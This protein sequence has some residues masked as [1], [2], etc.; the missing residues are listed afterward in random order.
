[1]DFYKDD[2]EKYKAGKLSP[3]ERHALEKKALSDP[4]LADAL[5]GVE[6]I[7][8]QEFSLDVQELNRKILGRKKNKWLWP[9]RIAASVIGVAIISTIIIYNQ[10]DQAVNLAGNQEKK[11]EISAPAKEDSTSQ[12]QLKDDDSVQTETESEKKDERKNADENLVAAV[13]ESKPKTKPKQPAETSRANSLAGA[14]GASQAT[15]PTLTVDTSSGI[16]SRTDTTNSADL[17]NTATETRVAQA[18][19]TIATQG[20]VSG[21]VTTSDTASGLA[22]AKVQMPTPSPA[23]DDKTTEEIALTSLPKTES[24]SRPER[25]GK[26]LARRNE[27]KPSATTGVIVKG[28]VRDQQGQPIPGVNIVAKGSTNG[29]VTDPEGKYSIE[30]PSTDQTLV[31]SFIGYEAQE[32]PLD[33]LKDGKLDISLQE[34]ATQLSEVVV[35]GYGVKRDGDEP[36]VRLAEPD[37]GRK[38]YDQYLDEKKIYPQQAIENKVEGKVTIEFTVG[39]TGALSDFQVVRKLGYGCDEE[40]IRLVKEGPQWKPSYINNEA[41]ESLVRIKTRFKLPGK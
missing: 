39:L 15:K 10:S 17:A 24:K 27:S 37:G 32:Q 41:V 1:M 22:L 38:A 33:K 5:E 36:I 2:I 3:A 12:A 30:V 28:V 34:D 8:S 4:F 26:Q 14:G 9:M 13:K 21:E 6:E 31:Y 20:P 35:T 16:L 7:S 11:N 18:D 19:Q 23:V 25:S 40:V 29:A